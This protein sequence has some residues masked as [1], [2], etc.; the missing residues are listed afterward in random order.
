MKSFALFLAFAATALA[1]TAQTPISPGQTVRGTLSAS[2]RML[3]DG[4]YADVYV[5]QAEAGQPYT[6][7]LRSSD[8]DAFVGVSYSGEGQFQAG[9]DDSAGGTDAELVFA[10]LAGGPVY[11]YANSLGQGETGAYM[12]TVTRGGTDPQYLDWEEQFAD[13]DWEGGEYDEAYF[14]DMADYAGAPMLARGQ[15]VN[16]RLGTGSD[17]FSDGSFFD[18]YRI[19]LRRGE[20]VTITMRSSDFD[21]FLMI[22]RFEGGVVTEELATDDDSAGGTDARLTFTADRDGVYV[23]RANALYEGVGGAYRLTVE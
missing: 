8:F 15:T 13:D 4:S 3:D 23:I 5:M 14:E 9:D 1:A 12:L 20:S 10:Y 17:L 2:D 11:I 7:T 18:P 6:V 22:G 21:T 16:G 19:Q